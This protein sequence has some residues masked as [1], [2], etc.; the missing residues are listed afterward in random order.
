M[1][2][3]AFGPRMASAAGS[4]N[5]VDGV[6]WKVVSSSESDFYK[7]CAIWRRSGARTIYMKNGGQVRKGSADRG[8]Q[9]AE[10]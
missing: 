2:Q 4:E 1:D 10:F 7:T 5:S 6:R 8:R 3:N 9:F